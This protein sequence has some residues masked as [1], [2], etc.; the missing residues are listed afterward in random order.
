ME[1]IRPP[2][3]SRITRKTP[4]GIDRSY[5]HA[6]AGASLWLSHAARP[7]RKRFGGWMGGEDDRC[8]CR[9]PGRCYG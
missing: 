6:R 5:F 7:R 1:S 4:S 2:A 9:T 3:A 8:G